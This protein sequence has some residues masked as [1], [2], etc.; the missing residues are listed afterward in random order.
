MI[1]ISSLDKLGYGFQFRNGL[2]DLFYNSKIVGYGFLFDRLYKIKLEQDNEYASFR[3]KN[4]VSKRSRI[5]DQSSMLWHKRLGHISK[6]RIQRLI[7]DNIL[8]SLDFGDLDTCVDCIRGKL[9]KTRKKSATRS[10]GL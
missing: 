4:S 8:V 3:V 5:K 2:V 6:E 10:G 9:T 1:S 7:K